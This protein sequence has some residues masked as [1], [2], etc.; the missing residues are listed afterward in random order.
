MASILNPYINF[1]GQ[2]REALGFYQSVFGG[3]L[4][5]MTF[6]DQGGMDLPE[7]EQ[8]KVMHG[9]LQTPTLTLMC[10]DAPSHMPRDEGSNIQISLSG[11]DEEE[12]TRWFEGLSAGG[13]VTLPLAKAPW[14]DSFGMLTDRFGVGW[15]TNI[16]GAATA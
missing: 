16:S 2:A 8:Q 15:M 4:S 11:D 9:Q 12:L 3:E 6:A 10:S 13:T 1:D 14:G 5:V 7:D